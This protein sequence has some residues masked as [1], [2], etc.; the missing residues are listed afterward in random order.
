[1]ILSFLV[2]LIIVKQQIILMIRYKSLTLVINK[3]FH[4]L[5]HKQPEVLTELYPSI[6]KAP[7]ILLLVTNPSD[8]KASPLVGMML[9]V[10]QERI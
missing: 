7:T 8:S 5:Q 9:M 10:L 4:H 2:V 3:F 1:M 6:L